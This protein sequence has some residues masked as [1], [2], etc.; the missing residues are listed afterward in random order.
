MGWSGAPKAQGDCIGLEIASSRVTPTH[1]LG[2]TLTWQERLLIMGE[3]PQEGGDREDCGPP[4]SS[5]DKERSTEDQ[6][7]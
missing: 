1:A 4:E 2:R 3:R 7:K 6:R 5:K